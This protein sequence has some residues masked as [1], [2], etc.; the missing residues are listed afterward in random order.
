MGPGADTRG[1]RTQVGVTLTVALCIG[2]RTWHPGRLG[3]CSS[4][5]EE[6]VPWSCDWSPSLTWTSG[7]S[8]C[9]I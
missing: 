3:Y 1:M 7:C 6:G 5:K 2:E 4:R 9:E 8:W